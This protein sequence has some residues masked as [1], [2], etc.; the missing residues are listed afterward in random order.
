MARGPH[1][2]TGLSGV[3]EINVGDGLKEVRLGRGYGLIMEM[4]G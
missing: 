4:I 2:L 3:Y 1:L